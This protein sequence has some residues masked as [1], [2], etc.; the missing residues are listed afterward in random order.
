[1]KVAVIGGGAAGFFA[2]L[3]VK[4]HHPK[5]YVILFEKS[6]K[7]L[8][9]VK[10]SG[11]GRCNVTNGSTSIKELSDAY[12]RGRR[13]MKKAL[14]QFSTSDTWKWYEMRGVLLK[15]E[16]DGRVFPQSDNS[17]SI[18]QCLIKDAEKNRIEIRMGEGVLSIQRKKNH[19]YKLHTK[20]EVITFE[21]VIIACGG[22][23]KRSG[24]DWI[25]VLDHKI[26]APVPSLF[27]FN[28]PNDK[29]QSLMG[30]VAQNVSV[31]IQGQSIKSEGPLLITHWGMSGP[32]ILKLSAFGARIL[33]DLEYSFKVNVNWVNVLN[34][35]DVK[36]QLIDIILKHPKKQL[37]SFR[38]FD[39]PDR[40]WLFLLDKFQL[41]HDKQWSDL[42]KKGIYKLI[43]M[44]CSDEYQVSGKTTF[45]EEFVTCGGVSLDSIN[46]TTMESIVSP[47]LYFAGEVLDIDGITGGYN[48]QAAWTTGFISGKLA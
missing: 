42:G 16:E 11:G 23:T 4:K 29:I 39:L 33:H 48:F 15:T 2:A 18:V 30:V 5:A 12:P 26:I 47:G 20:T 17:S 1:M 34:H 32:A 35:D 38:A 10:I 37:S 25:S 8:S 43:A 45:K 19:C 41:P 36:S 3:S 14:K 28:M 6:K 7:L 40:L 9:K 46:T 13:L 27:T 44:L 24:F 31:N 21:K 22:S